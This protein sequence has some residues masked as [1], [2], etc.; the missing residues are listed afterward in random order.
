MKLFFFLFAILINLGT[1]ANDT[2]PT[3]KT[4]LIKD[5]ANVETPLLTYQDR[6]EL[7]KFLRENVL[8]KDEGVVKGILEWLDKKYQQKAQIYN[9]KLK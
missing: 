2:I 3:K 1:F 9:G 5:S 6:V 4:P 8:M 7:E